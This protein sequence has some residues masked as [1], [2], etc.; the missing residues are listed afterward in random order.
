LR[1]SHDKAS[2]ARK[3]GSRRA[4]DQQRLWSFE[5]KIRSSDEDLDVG[6]SGPR[7]PST[8]KPDHDAA[9]NIFEA[10]AARASLL[11]VA[12]LCIEM[13][14]VQAARARLALGAPATRIQ[15]R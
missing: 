5:G 1:R 9:L 3:R 8:R 6:V 14:I 13:G 4:R 11:R 12:C 2:A 15:A 7:A 10:I